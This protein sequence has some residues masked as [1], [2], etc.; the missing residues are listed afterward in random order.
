MVKKNKQAQARTKEDCR[1]LAIA[2]LESSVGGLTLITP[3]ARYHIY[4]R[5]V[6][7]VEPVANYD[8]EVREE[9]KKLTDRILVAGGFFSGDYRVQFNR[10]IPIISPN[11]II[12]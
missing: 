7:R 5:R 3:N 8:K 11:Q 12:K 10:K 2:N 1:Y 4:E 9:M 6:Q